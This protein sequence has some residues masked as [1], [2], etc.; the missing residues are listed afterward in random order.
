MIKEDLRLRVYLA[1]WSGETEYREYCKKQYGHMMDLVDPMTITRSQILEK[2]G[3]N[4]LDT[5]IV[6][7]DKKLILSC[8]ALL[9]QIT[10]G[11][12]FGTTIEISFSYENGLPVYVIDSTKKFRSDPWLS[13]HTTK[14]FD[15]IDEFFEFALGN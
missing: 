4:G 8:D 14:F 9:A 13:F 3:I 1:G 7:R 15:S 12:T 6:R 10:I 11:S 2:I 5:F